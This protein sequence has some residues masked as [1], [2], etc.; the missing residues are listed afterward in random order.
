MDGTRIANGRDEKYSILVLKT[1]GKR[2]EPCVDVRKLLK[3]D[4]KEV[5]CT[6]ADWI[7]SV[8]AAVW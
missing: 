5:A 4:H 1:D 6:C 2:E 7:P 3:A 8:Q